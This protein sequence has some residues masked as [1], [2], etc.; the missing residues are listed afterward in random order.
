[1]QR[2]DM[3]A[4]VEAAYQARRSG[5]FAALEA[6]VSP[7]AK[8]CYGGEQS[9]LASVPASGAGGVVQ[10]ARELFE[11]IEI[12]SLERVQAVAEGNRVAIPVEHHPRSARRRAVRHADVRPV[13]VRRPWPDLLRN[14]VPR[15]G[16][17]RRGDAVA[18]S[19]S[20]SLPQFGHRFVGAAWRC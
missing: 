12:R 6:I 7:E 5:D 3:L 1:M 16:Q 18:N 19:R 10:A 20:G 15:H 8:F 2:D 11:R 4:K 9:L 17:A 13:G 14:A